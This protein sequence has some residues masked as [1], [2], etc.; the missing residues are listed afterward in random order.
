MTT[1]KSR[2]HQENPYPPNCLRIQ[3]LAPSMALEYYFENAV[4]QVLMEG[5]CVT[6]DLGM[7]HLSFQTLIARVRVC[8]RARVG[9]NL[10]CHVHPN[11]F[12][13]SPAVQP[14]QTTMVSI[15]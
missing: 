1:H 8:V 5:K 15:L 3:R 9:C 14:Q 13:Q 7:A 6:P 11:F 2:E 4:K 12:Q 10:F